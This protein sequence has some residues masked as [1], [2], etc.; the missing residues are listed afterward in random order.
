[1]QNKQTMQKKHIDQISLS[2]PSV[3]ITM[4]N[5][6]KV[7]GMVRDAVEVHEDSYTTRKKHMKIIWYGHALNCLASAL[8][9]T[10]KGKGEDIVE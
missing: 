8:Q 5:N 3:V 4:L 1:M 6:E 9:E 10:E 2:S 7:C